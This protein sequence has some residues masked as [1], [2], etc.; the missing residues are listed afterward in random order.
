M[1]AEVLDGIRLR[2]QQQGYDLSQLLI[3]PVD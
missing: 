2:L 3:S 1:E